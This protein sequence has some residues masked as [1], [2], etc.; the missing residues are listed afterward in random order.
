[1]R[2][3]SLLHVDH[4]DVRVDRKLEHAE[5]MG[6]VRDEL[7][8]IGFPRDALMR[9]S[10]NSILG[11]SPSS[12]LGDV[13]R[14]GH[15]AIRAATE[16]ERV[17]EHLRTVPDDAIDG[18]FSVPPIDPLADLDDEWGWD[19]TTRVAVAQLARVAPEVSVRHYRVMGDMYVDARVGDRSARFMERG[20]R[21]AYLYEL[22]DLLFDLPDG[23]GE[24]LIVA[25]AR[26]YRRGMRDGYESGKDEWSDEAAYFP[27]L[28]DD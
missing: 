27:Y 20:V 3:K 8:R 18:A 28:D 22:N 23:A 25:M 11:R 10:E 1:M 17:V 9:R 26:A 19:A 4:D 12:M 7:V 21:P 15:V 6:Q 5:L 2:V 16:P 14:D 24:D 13:G